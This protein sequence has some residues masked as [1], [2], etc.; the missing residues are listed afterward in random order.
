MQEIREDLWSAIQ[1]LRHE[2][3]FDMISL[4]KISIL[5]MELLG[6]GTFG[7]VFSP[8]FHENPPR[9]SDD[10]DDDCDYTYSL[11]IFF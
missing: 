10:D 6:A 8:F 2:M 9:D 4:E 1:N 5:T 11:G 3:N 7:S